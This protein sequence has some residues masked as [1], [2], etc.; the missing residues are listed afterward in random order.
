MNTVR[1]SKDEFIAAIMN[2]QRKNAIAKARR[3]QDIFME[4]RKSKTQRLKRYE[5]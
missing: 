1:V 5:R 3:E 2:Q 4:Y